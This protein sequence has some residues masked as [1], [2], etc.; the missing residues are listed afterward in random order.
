M[1]NPNVA[2]ST[3]KQIEIMGEGVSGTW[4]VQEQ[5]LTLLVD[6]SGE[7][8]FGISKNGVSTRLAMFQGNLGDIRIGVNATRKIQK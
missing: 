6:L 8:D 7:V 3:R 2:K 4:D 5:T 1:A